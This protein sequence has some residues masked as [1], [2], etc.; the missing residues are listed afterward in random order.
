[1]ARGPRGLTPQRGLGTAIRVLREQV[2]MTGATLAEKSGTSASW[3]SQ[4]EQGR[5]DPTWATMERLSKALDV[6]M[7]HLAELAEDFEETDAR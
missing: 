5:V 2:K 1:M 4:I 6:S 3:I 7:E